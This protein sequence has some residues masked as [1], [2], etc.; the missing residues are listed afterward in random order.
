MF[1]EFSGRMQ[2]QSAQI[3]SMEL[4]PHQLEQFCQYGDMLLEWNQRMNLTSI[5]DP[6]EIILKHFIDSLALAHAVQGGKLADIG[7]G[8]GFPGIPLKILRPE[9]DVCLVDS[10]AKR[11]EFLNAVVSNL[12]LTKIEAVHARA[13]DLGRNDRYRA[14]FDSVTSRAVARLPILLE[15]A[16]PLLKLNGRFLA[17]K[18]LVA[19]QE[20]NESAMALELLGGELRAIENYVLGDGAEHRALVI[21]EK[22]KK[23]PPAYPRRA[24]IPAKKPLV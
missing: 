13:E 24:G 17:A 22:V 7:T 5:T 2:E 11:V 6:E 23:T 15:Y 4:T 9:L 18:G 1:R 20:V 12:N 21:V 19:E 16:I 14:G 3:L 8:A 10:L